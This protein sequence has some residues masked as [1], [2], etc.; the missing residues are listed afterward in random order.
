MYGP[1]DPFGVEG[2]SKNL[3]SYFYIEN[4]NNGR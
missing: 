3:K 4:K 2:V 1:F